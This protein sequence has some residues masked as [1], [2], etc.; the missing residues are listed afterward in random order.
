[1]PRRWKPRS[2]TA[3]CRAS[4]RTA[5]IS[6][7]SRPTPRPRPGPAAGPAIDIAGE[8]DRRADLRHPGRRRQRAGVQ[9]HHSLGG[10]QEFLDGTTVALD[11][12]SRFNTAWHAG[13]RDLLHRPATRRATPYLAEANRLVP[14][15]ARRAAPERRQRDAGEDAAA[16]AVDRGRRRAHGGQRGRLRRAVPAPVAAQ[17]LP[18]RS[19]RGRA[20]ARQQRPAGDPRRPRLGGAYEQSPVRIP[21]STRISRTEFDDKAP[22]IDRS[23]MIVAYCTCPDELT[24]ARRSRTGSMGWGTPRCGSS[25]AGWRRGRTP[26]CRSRR[27]AS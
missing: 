2:R 7:S 24:S 10:G 25:R 6:R 5:P 19:L 13:L 23:R 15:R 11:E 16:L 12:P 14:R 17:P 9:L 20:A 3:P 1:M 22:D 8:V 21:R 18:D 26:A 27:K 4:S